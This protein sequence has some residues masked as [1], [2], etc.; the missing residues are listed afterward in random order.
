M[1]VAFFSKT[2]QNFEKVRLVPQS[3]TKMLPKISVACPTNDSI[4]TFSS[5]ISGVPI[6]KPPP[7]NKPP[8]LFVGPQNLRESAGS[9]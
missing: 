2:V 4:F 9:L 5:S 8:P 6:N 7:C 1:C 3:T